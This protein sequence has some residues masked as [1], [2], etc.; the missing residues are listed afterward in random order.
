[1]EAN[2][3]AGQAQ[4]QETK[5]SDKH[6]L[7]ISRL[8]VIPVVA[9]SIYIAYVKPEP[10]ILL[11][12]AFDVVFAGCIVPLVGGARSLLAEIELSR[13]DICGYCRFC[14]ETRPL[15]YHT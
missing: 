3:V 5:T 15:L 12:L 14:I 2:K 1:M 10:G 6:L 9:L 7:V 11:I 8:M 13:C 4:N